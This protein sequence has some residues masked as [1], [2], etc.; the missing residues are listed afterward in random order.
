M[1]PA[2]L[3]ITLAALTMT[4]SL[5]AAWQRLSSLES[6]PVDLASTSA[7]GKTKIISSKAIGQPENLI[8]DN[9]GVS[10]NA[11][12]GAS[13]VVIGF[14]GPSA[15]S[16]VTFISE[17]AEGRVSVEG[18]LDKSKWTP[19]SQTVFTAA[20]RSIS[21]RFAAASASYLKVQ[22]DLSKGGLIK[23]LS[24]FGSI[25]DKDY[26]VTEAPAGESPPSV[27]GAGGVGG[28]R[29][30]YINPSSAQGSE[31]A[32]KFGSFEFPESPD[33]FRTVIYD[34][35]QVRTLTEFGS[36][37]SPRPVRFSAYAFEKELPE[38]E[39]W[40]GRMSFDPATFDSMTPVATAEDV[41][42]VGYIKTKLNK[43]VRARYV[44]LRWEPDFNPPAFGVPAFSVSMSG[45][46]VGGGPG[47]GG[48]GGGG[49]QGPGGGGTG[50]GGGNNPGNNPQGDYSGGG[51][52]FSNPFSFG[53][54][55]YGGGG[56]SLPGNGGGGG[57]GTP[58]GPTDPNA[59]P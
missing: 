58:G 27:N 22:F 15:L 57:G 47:S 33:K 30:I 25:T 48:G 17:G 56:G 21:L 59:S 37:H 16:Y 1:K 42:G 35:G 29:I 36:V 46:N 20:D 31:M 28:G 11:N 45:L 14:G 2:L 39:D 5:Q 19:L 10:S 26:E 38:K 4:P 41:K 6:R 12:A 51:A 18:S 8:S 50:G 55:G 9:I 40:R 54:G 13:E 53:T 32:A 43:P 52:P 3:T 34:F 7:A 23:S 24:V 49:G 44:A